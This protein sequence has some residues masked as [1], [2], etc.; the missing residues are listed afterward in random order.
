MISMLEREGYK[1]IFLLICICPDHRYTTP[2]DGTLSKSHQAAHWTGRYDL[3][4]PHPPNIPKTPKTPN[5]PRPLN[6]QLNS[7]I[8]IFITAGVSLFLSLPTYGRYIATSLHS[9]N[10][11]THPSSVGAISPSKYHIHQYPSLI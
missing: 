4:P 10:T 2:T 3:S 9:N 7:S 5:K 6:Q 8:F 11:H 1:V